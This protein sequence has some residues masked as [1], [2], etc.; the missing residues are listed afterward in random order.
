M[1]I[2]IGIIGALAAIVFFAYR[3]TYVAREGQEVIS[4]AKGFIR[5]Q[6]WNARH[7]HNLLDDIEDPREIG[8]LLMTETAK[9]KGALT[10]AVGLYR[11]FG[12]V[13]I[14]KYYDN[15]HENVLYMELALGDMPR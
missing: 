5:R 8:V 7:R 1:H 12:F 2:L 13:E 14:D 6:R 11:D 9:Y 4:D 15:P 10:A 3:L